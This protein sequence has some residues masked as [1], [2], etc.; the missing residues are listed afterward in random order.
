M[1]GDSRISSRASPNAWFEGLNE[2]AFRRPSIVVRECQEY[3]SRSVLDVSHV[4]GCDGKTGEKLTFP[5]ILVVG[6]IVYG[7]PSWPFTR[8]VS[9]SERLQQVLCQWGSTSTI[10]KRKNGR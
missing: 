9:R 5:R 3:E 1:E 8:A 10:E 7:V 4:R 6:P 2:L